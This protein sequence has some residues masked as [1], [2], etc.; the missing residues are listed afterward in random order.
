M[1]VLDAPGDMGKSVSAIL[2]K[3]EKLEWNM[4]CAAEGLYSVD[5]VCAVIS[6]TTRKKVIYEKIAVGEFREIMG[7]PAVVAYVFVDGFSFGE[8]FRCFGPGEEGMIRW[9][10]ASARGSLSTLEEVLCSASFEP[11][12]KKAWRATH[13]RGE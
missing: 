9:G 11:G 5:E 13:L 7:L 4:L 8:E 2:A 6:K 12:V 3:T 1:P 10:K